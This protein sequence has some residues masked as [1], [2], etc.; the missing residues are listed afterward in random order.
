MTDIQQIVI[1]HSFLCVI[2]LIAG[3]ALGHSLYRDEIK[4]RK[5]TMRWMK[6]HMKKEKR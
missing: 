6:K 2:C 1:G 4:K 3:I 5:Q